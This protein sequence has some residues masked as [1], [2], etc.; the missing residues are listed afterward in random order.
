MLKLPSGLRI[1]K[2]RCVASKL[3]LLHQLLR[4][5]VFAFQKPSHVNVEFDELGRL[6]LVPTRRLAQEHFESI[7]RR[8]VIFFLQRHRCEIELGLAKF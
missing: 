3:E 2:R 6:A 4:A 7:A 1:I 8:R 5:A